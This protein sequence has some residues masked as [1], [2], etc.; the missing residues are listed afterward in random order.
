MVSASGDNKRS[1]LRVWDAGTGGVLHVHEGHSGWVNSVCALGDGRVGSSSSTGLVYNA[2]N[3]LRVWDASTG[4]CLE[5]AAED[6]P[7]GA[8]LKAQFYAAP[9]G[10]ADP[11][12]NRTRTHFF[13]N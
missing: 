2:D 12:I 9:S 6:S 1:T 4:A 10:D 5:T 8:E 7:R 3:T 11:P 13:S